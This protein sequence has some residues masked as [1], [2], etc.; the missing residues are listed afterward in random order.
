V[1]VCG[2]GD[3]R[4]GAKGRVEKTG[5]EWRRAEKINAERTEGGRRYTEQRERGF[6]GAGLR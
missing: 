5:E 6:L 1:V 3:N 4:E 2:D